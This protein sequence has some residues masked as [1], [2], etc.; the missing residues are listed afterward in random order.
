MINWQYGP[1]RELNKRFLLSKITCNLKEKQVSVG[2]GTYLHSYTNFYF[3]A[4]FDQS[5]YD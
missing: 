1:A 2:Y 4:L 5:P 3:M